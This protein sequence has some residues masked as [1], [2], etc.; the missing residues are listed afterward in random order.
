[1]KKYN[2]DDLG[3]FRDKKTPILFS[4]YNKIYEGF[5]YHTSG[6]I[7]LYFP[8]YDIFA[9]PDEWF[10]DDLVDEFPAGS[11]IVGPHY[12]NAHSYAYLADLLNSG[13]LKI[14]TF[15]DIW[16]LKRTGKWVKE[17]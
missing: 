6:D 12:K 10:I 7:I 9:Y 13:R 3:N 14:L 17:N 1:M 15:S 2:Y 16:E 8:K 4:Y 5:L 11:F